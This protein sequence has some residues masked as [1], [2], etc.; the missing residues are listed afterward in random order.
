MLGSARA[1]ILPIWSSLPLE[2]PHVPN[3]DQR[4][5]CARGA[6]VKLSEVTVLMLVFEE[7][8]NDALTQPSVR[9][10]VMEKLDVMGVSVSVRL[11]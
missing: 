5:S 1:G 11:S 2:A 4:H 6:F 9:L 7:M 10:D 8:S 3:N